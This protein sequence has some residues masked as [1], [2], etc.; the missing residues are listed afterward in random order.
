M[1][2]KDP[3][4]TQEVKGHVVFIPKKLHPVRV[5]DYI[6]LALLNAHYKILENII[7]NRFE[8]ILQELK[9]LQ[10]HCG[11]QGSLCLKLFRK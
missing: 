6:P 11:I 1:F 10:K 4:V 3:L 8:P 7:A 5:E 9:H 2:L